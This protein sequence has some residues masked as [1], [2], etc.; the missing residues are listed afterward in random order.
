MATDRQIIAVKLT[1]GSL[2]TH[3]AHYR[4]SYIANLT[5]RLATDYNNV[6]GTY[7]KLS[8]DVYEKIDDPTYRIIRSTPL[9]VTPPGWNG[10]QNRFGSSC[11]Q[12]MWYIVRFKPEWDDNG[13]K[14]NERLGTLKNQSFDYAL[15]DWGLI[16]H[17]DKR[18]VILFRETIPSETD[19]FPFPRLPYQQQAIRIGLERVQAWV[20]Y[21]YQVVGDSVSTAQPISTF[22]LL[23]TSN[24]PLLEFLREIDQTEVFNPDTP[25]YES[26]IRY[27]VSSDVPT[28]A[29]N[30]ARFRY[31][32]GNVG[33]GNTN[34]YGK[35]N[36]IDF[37]SYRQNRWNGTPIYFFENFDASLDTGGYIVTYVP[38][39]RFSPAAKPL[40]ADAIMEDIS[41][42]GANNLLIRQNISNSAMLYDLD[43]RIPT[44]AP[45]VFEDYET[46]EGY[47]NVEVPV[48]FE[49][50]NR[51]LFDPGDDAGLRPH[52]KDYAGNGFDLVNSLLQKDSEDN[53]VLFQ[54]NYI[55]RN[56]RTISFH[57]STNNGF[58]VFGENLEPLRS[59]A[60]VRENPDGTK[61]NPT[62]LETMEIK[63]RLDPGGLRNAN[64][65]RAYYSTKQYDGTL[66]PA[67]QRFHIAGNLV[68]GPT[69]PERQWSGFNPSSDL[70]NDS[71]QK[72]W[73]PY[74]LKIGD[75]ADRRNTNPNKG[76]AGTDSGGNSSNLQNHDVPFGHYERVDDT[77]T[78]EWRY[79]KWNQP[80][81]TTTWVD[82]NPAAGFL[83]N[84][85]KF[86]RIRD[87]RIVFVAAAD[88]GPAIIEGS[89]NPARFELRE[90]NTSGTLTAANGNTT[91]GARA[92]VNPY[93]VNDPRYNANYVVR[94]WCKAQRMKDSDPFLP[95]YLATTPD[96]GSQCL[97]Q[98]N[99]SKFAWNSELSAASECGTLATSTEITIASNQYSV[100]TSATNKKGTGASFKVTTDGSG[101]ISNIEYVSGGNN[102][103][104]P[105]EKITVTAG[106]CE[107]LNFYIA[108]VTLTSS[109][110]DGWRGH[111]LHGDLSRR[112]DYN[113]SAASL[114]N[115]ATA[116]PYHFGMPGFVTAPLLKGR[117]NIFHTEHRYNYN[118]RFDNP[119]QEYN[120]DNAEIY[121][122]AGEDVYDSGAI[123]DT[124]FAKVQP[125]EPGDVGCAIFMN[126]LERGQQGQT[127]SGVNSSKY[128]L[129]M[130][131]LIAFFCGGNINN[132]N[133]SNFNI[134][135]DLINGWE[136]GTDIFN[137]NTLTYE[138]D[139]DISFQVFA[140]AI[141]HGGIPSNEF[142]FKVVVQAYEKD[143]DTLVDTVQ[144]EISIGKQHEGNIV[145]PDIQF[146][147]NTLVF[148]GGIVP[149]PGNNLGGHVSAKF[150]NIK[151]KKNNR[152]LHEY[153]CTAQDAGTLRSISASTFT[154]NEDEGTNK[155]TFTFS[156]TSRADKPGDRYA[157]TIRS[158][159]GNVTSEDFIGDVNFDGEF[160][161]DDYKKDTLTLTVKADNKLEGD[162]QL[163]ISLVR[164]NVSQIVTI[165]DTSFPSTFELIG[166]PAP[167][168]VSEEQRTS[169]SQLRFEDFQSHQ[170]FLRN[171]A[172]NNNFIPSVLTA[173]SPLE[174]STFKG[175]NFSGEDINGVYNYLSNVE[176]E[177]EEGTYQ[178]LR[179]VDWSDDYYSVYAI[180]LINWG[181]PAIGI[182]LEGEGVNG[183]PNFRI[184][185][186][187]IGMCPSGFHLPGF[188]NK[189][190]PMGF[191][192]TDPKYVNADQYM[193]SH[194]SLPPSEN[195]V[196]NYP[197][198]APWNYAHWD[199]VPRIGD[200][201]QNQIPL[202]VLSGR[203]RFE[204]ISDT[205]YRA[206][207]TT[208][209]YQY[210]YLTDTN[211]IYE[212]LHKQPQLFAGLS[213]NSEKQPLIHNFGASYTNIDD[214]ENVL[215]LRFLQ[216]NSLLP[217]GQ[218]RSMRELAYQA[219]LFES[220]G[221]LNV[222]KDL[223]TGE[224]SSYYGR[225]SGASFILPHGYNSG[226]ALLDL[227]N[228]ILGNNFVQYLQ[229]FIWQI[230]LEEDITLG[231]TGPR[232]VINVY[233]FQDHETLQ[234][235]RGLEYN[236]NQND[237]NIGLTTYNDTT[238]NGE[239]EDGVYKETIPKDPNKRGN[240]LLSSLGVSRNVM[241][242]NRSLHNPLYGFIRKYRMYHDTS[243]ESDDPIVPTTVKWKSVYSQGNNP[244]F[245][246]QFSD[247][248]VTDDTLHTVGTTEVI[249]ADLSK[250]N[251][252]NDYPVA[253]TKE[254][255]TYNGIIK[256]YGWGLYRKGVYP[257]IVEQFQSAKPDFIQLQEQQIYG[258]IT[259]NSDLPFNVGDPL[260]FDTITGEGLEATPNYDGTVFTDRKTSYLEAL[261]N[262]DD[263]Y[264]EGMS[265]SDLLKNP[266]LGQFIRANHHF[267]GSGVSITHTDSTKQRHF[268]DES[269]PV[270]KLFQEDPDKI[271]SETT[272][273]L[274]PTRT[275]INGSYTI[276]PGV[277]TLRRR[278]S[279]TP[280]AFDIQNA[281]LDQQDSTGQ[282]F[283]IETQRRFNTAYMNGRIYNPKL[284]SARVISR[285]LKDSLLTEISSV[286][287]N[288]LV[289]DISIAGERFIRDDKSVVI[290]NLSARSELLYNLYED[291]FTLISNVEDSP[292]RGPD[293]PSNQIFQ[294]PGLGDDSP[295]IFDN[296]PTNKLKIT[297][298]T[299][300]V[301]AGTQV[302]F[303][304]KAFATQTDQLFDTRMT[305]DDFKA[306]GTHYTGLSKLLLSGFASNES[307]AY[308][309]DSPPLASKTD[310]IDFALINFRDVN[311]FYTLINQ[312]PYEYTA[313]SPSMVYTDDVDGETSS[314]AAN[315]FQVK[316]SNDNLRWTIDVD[317]KTIS[318]AAKTFADDPLRSLGY[319]KYIG[320]NAQANKPAAAEITTGSTSTD[321]GT[322][323]SGPTYS[324]V[325]TNNFKSYNKFNTSI[326]YTGSSTTGDFSLNFSK[327]D[328]VYVNP[329]SY[330]DGSQGTLSTDY[331]I[332]DP[333]RGVKI[334]LSRDFGSGASKKITFEGN[335][336]LNPE[337]TV[338]DAGDMIVKCVAEEADRVT[339]I[340]A[341][342]KFR[343]KPWRS[344]VLEKYDTTQ[345]TSIRYTFTLSGPVPDALKSLTAG[346][347]VRFYYT[348]N[349]A[350][351]G[352]QLENEPLTQS[353][354]PTRPNWDYGHPDWEIGHK[355]VALLIVILSLF[356]LSQESQGDY[357]QAGLFGF[358]L[359]T[360]LGPLAA[361]AGIGSL[362]GDTL[363][364]DPSVPRGI[365]LAKTGYFNSAGYPNPYTLESVDWGAKRFSI[366]IPVARIVPNGSQEG[367]SIFR[368][369]AITGK[370]IPPEH[371]GMFVAPA[372]SNIRFE[373]IPDP[374]GAYSFTIKDPREIRKRPPDPEDPTTWP[375]PTLPSGFSK[376]IFN[377]LVRPDTISFAQF[378]ENLDLVGQF[379]DAEDIEYQLAWRV[380]DVDYTKIINQTT[381]E[382][383]FVPEIIIHFNDDATV[384]KE[385]VIFGEI[386][387][388]TK[389]LYGVIVQDPGLIRT[390]GT[391]TQ[392]DGSTASGKNAP[393]INSVEIRGGGP[394]LNL[395]TGGSLL[396][397]IQ[398]PTDINNVPY[399]NIEPNYSLYRKGET[400]SSI[401]QHGTKSLF[402]ADRFRS[403]HF[404]PPAGT[405]KTS[406]SKSIFRSSND[407]PGFV[408]ADSPLHYESA[409]NIGNIQWED[410]FSLTN[411]PNQE[412]DYDLANL[413]G[414]VAQ[415]LLFDEGL[416]VVRGFFT[417]DKVNDSGT[418][419]EAR[420]RKCRGSIELTLN[421]DG[422]IIEGDEVLHFELDNGQAQPLRYKINNNYEGFTL[423]TE[424]ERSVVLDPVNTYEQFNDKIFWTPG[425][426]EPN[427]T[428]TPEY[429]FLVRNGSGDAQ[430][431]T[432]N[433]Y[434]DDKDD[435]RII[436][437]IEYN[438]RIKLSNL[439]LR[440]MYTIKTFPE[441]KFEYQ[442]RESA[443]ETRNKFSRQLI[444]N[445]GDK[446]AFK[447]I[448]GPQSPGTNSPGF[449]SPQIVNIDRTSNSPN[450]TGFLVF[451]SPGQQYN[452]D[453][454][455]ANVERIGWPPNPEVDSPEL[456][457]AIHTVE[458]D[459]RP[460]RH[461]PY[462]VMWQLRKEDTS[463]GIRIVTTRIELVEYL[464]PV[465]NTTGEHLGDLVAP[466]TKTPPPPADF[467][468][469]GS[470]YDSP[471]TYINPFNLNG[472]YRRVGGDRYRKYDNDN[473]YTKFAIEQQGIEGEQ[474]TTSGKA[475]WLILDAK[476][477]IV[478]HESVNTY[479]WIDNTQTSSLTNTVP[480]LRSDWDPILPSTAIIE[481]TGENQDGVLDI[482][483]EGF[484]K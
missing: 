432:T 476:N 75:D 39:L 88:S 296:S 169:I 78:P 399:T 466:F 85:G 134:C 100:S 237:A 103:Y 212:A 225:Y 172:Q 46:L 62:M 68:G 112:S 127:V 271:I 481:P 443:I 382:F 301:D 189:S 197:G 54:E 283:G 140:K 279:R 447:V 369:E 161:L 268:Y 245:R 304:I 97:A 74:W 228:N 309:G 316:W 290:P 258:S 116:K 129:A 403:H 378:T 17:N 130:P 374:S 360:V 324:S 9:Q 57:G 179:D 239:P 424:A 15:Y 19:F 43:K 321:G 101:K 329:G 146:Q 76:E 244:F 198:S 348:P 22:N 230:E 58:E 35:T 119:L 77:G 270:M 108:E 256:H 302:P 435:D 306:P 475:K 420:Q 285:W 226:D 388:A 94:A 455:V 397:S 372:R 152:I 359:S 390:A 482:T 367:I 84:N 132:G 82:S 184:V 243:T 61:S 65:A 201:L 315:A 89:A 110:F 158:L 464:K 171:L 128:H 114:N 150:K 465:R 124:D 398:D 325:L 352:S 312:S 154:I 95:I 41:F 255:D 250:I 419:A 470:T 16:K 462:W 137:V 351:T 177:H 393:V 363:G 375:T 113:S 69:A 408:F 49:A 366:K 251:E 305:N 384:V 222:I 450:G 195:E 194:L 174:F 217:E 145:V 289:E 121:D 131:T 404:N 308:F 413:E 53:K 430:Y 236:L 26:E 410:T 293:S 235:V 102:K 99:P 414:G 246:E 178:L 472:P 444:F 56:E 427:V 67:D 257:L 453:D 480:T 248:I 106:A 155:V 109:D 7:T 249:R 467:S 380:S 115:A 73:I 313:D 458:P 139:L 431:E 253:V 96:A 265:L 479:P 332:A 163:I 117:N 299:T 330:N 314:V 377:G 242:S 343:P 478:F 153:D 221:T 442:I 371:V 269:T 149:A 209:E 164:F 463:T 320:A 123:E 421:D 262:A 47:A 418:D 126:N 319:H 188:I 355:I 51:L 190:K 20:T 167:N 454:L 434:D 474:G 275:Y 229:D 44:W 92:N 405:T 11:Q 286:N 266:S 412:P 4:D 24:G 263:H 441:V 429:A 415:D 232:W 2:G 328:V 341:A 356:S 349:V 151:I 14:F 6:N 191:D 364:G 284:G 317:H 210:R 287:I 206:L 278:G 347:Q 143:T 288:D 273:A 200:I 436:A 187:L 45:N 1:G 135:L 13:T 370:P 426:A 422:N 234:R 331:A 192:P 392:A 203:R 122:F 438:R 42:D 322:F 440:G 215:P 400:S 60:G 144:D 111:V 3:T 456:T 357:V 241:S 407:S 29:G 445:E 202:P 182:N 32:T 227:H 216:L 180:D 346:D 159:S 252:W 449:N 281:I 63:V 334:S 157:Y 459:Q 156:S 354:N 409:Q 28:S 460:L 471:G 344:H 36:A 406:V 362:I 307:P 240:Y 261:K 336:T 425:E 300:G 339:Y 483:L 208:T 160:I 345:A 452:I 8:N 125:N 337:N 295:S 327:G 176:M 238:D 205:V 387:S 340:Y 196:D 207:P 138:Y 383:I 451:D 199:D 365:V 211:T 353:T 350:L 333:N 220:K 402:T 87:I 311:G 433:T 391:T 231:D 276:A 23:D 79:V 165:Q 318:H 373:Q 247:N 148:A 473:N 254:D 193:F 457:R 484:D 379:D 401:W 381:D 274:F 395:S 141:S 48:P 219:R 31:K 50:P 181:T 361:L 389:E 33:A 213:E 264:I 90:F 233:Q 448:P 439:R 411:S 437:E 183:K 12:K 310:N 142:F 428:Y 133:T 186:S 260:N 280:L 70:S 417:L 386:D 376:D 18:W 38:P 267:Y 297:L 27:R 358:L 40:R 91:S 59:S 294:S 64:F 105:G 173:P 272:N 80:F 214:Q 166:D 292:N 223:G 136:N 335:F 446:T 303:T 83:Q 147:P 416:G 323:F 55:M 175:E 461:I 98:G 326:P 118:H 277:G 338:K 107:D 185:D 72:P 162:E 342:D 52:G 469:S 170:S 37:D 30:T 10:F 168:P 204:R 86:S 218:G 34:A 71:V 224:Q 385:P 5:G 291:P 25:I 396:G 104:W 93:D 21:D 259:W 423:P 468:P 477:N 66:A 282:V 120:D 298:N 81:G 368:A 394:L